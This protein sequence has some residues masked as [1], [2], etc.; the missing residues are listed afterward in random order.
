MAVSILEAAKI[1]MGQGDIVK[2]TVMELYARSSDLLRVMQFDNISGN[3]LVFNREKTL[4]N[5][6]FRGVNEGYTEGTGKQDKVNEPLTIAGGD[7]DVD[8]FIVDTMGMSQ[9]A[10]QEAGKIKALA[11]SWTKTAIK[12]DTVSTPREFDGL[13]ARISS[14]YTVNNGTATGG[15]FLSLAKLDE[16][17]DTC[18]SPTHLIM[19]KTM[20]R[21]LTAAARNP[22]VSGYITYTQD[23]FGRSVT[24]Y[25]DLPIL[26]ADKDNTN[27]AIMPFTEANPVGGGTAASTSIYCVSMMEDGLVGLQNGDMSVRDMGELEDKPTFRT[28]VEWYTTIAILRENSV[29]RLN[30]IKDGAVTV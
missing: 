22:D 12:G 29:A 26:I 21:R 19:N 13:Q 3:A 24:K 11:L 30:G 17:I 8:K 7:L 14:S 10:V 6:G 28:R 5:I 27:T 4:P 2:A 15:T 9:R 20:R 18:D 1:A 23:E 16:L 25:N